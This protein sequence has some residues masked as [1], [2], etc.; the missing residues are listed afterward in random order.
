MSIAAKL[1]EFQTGKILLKMVKIPFKIFFRVHAFD[2]CGYI[3]IV[4]VIHTKANHSFSTRDRNN[5]LK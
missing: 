5:N 4:F 1:N 2:V 3:I